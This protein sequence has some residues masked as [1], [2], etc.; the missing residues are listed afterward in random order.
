[1][2]NREMYDE[3]LENFP[4]DSRLN[5]FK[6]ETCSEEQV[7][8]IGNYSDALSELKAE[9]DRI[10]TKLELING[11]RE[12]ALRLAPFPKGDDGKDIKYTEGI[13]KATLAEDPQIIKYKDQLNDIESYLYKFEAKVNSLEHR[14]SQLN[15]L[16]SLFISGYYSQPDAT[17]KK[18]SKSD[19]V[20]DS[21]RSGINKKKRSS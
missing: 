2:E 7:S 18:S 6:L 12:M 5:R 20:S 10:T 1:M 11:K 14:R 13:M 17:K 4:S 9:K 8:L 21:V 19:D 15:N 3:L 16:T